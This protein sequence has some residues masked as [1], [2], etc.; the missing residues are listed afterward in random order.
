LFQT[1]SKKIETTVPFINILCR[2]NVDK[3]KGFLMKLKN[4]LL[5]FTAIAALGIIACADNAA[6]TGNCLDGP[7][8][9]QVAGNS[10]SDVD[11]SS[12]SGETTSGET[13]PGE[14]TSGE[15]TPG[16]TTSGETTSGE[17][18]PGETTSGEATSGGETSGETTSGNTDC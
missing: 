7:A 2:F 18:T 13:T 9:R 8:A 4:I 10:S 17:T 11:A 3:I 1:I 12:A 15:T 5:P 6:L 16:E 14:T